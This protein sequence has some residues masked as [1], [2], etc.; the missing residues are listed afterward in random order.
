VKAGSDLV[1]LSS[2]SRRDRRGS[3][4]QACELG[5]GTR[6]RC[7]DGVVLIDRIRLE[8]ISATVTVVAEGDEITFAWHEM[9]DVVEA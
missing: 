4:W 7:K 3:R 5:L 2:H 9:V 1:Q 6:V 8:P